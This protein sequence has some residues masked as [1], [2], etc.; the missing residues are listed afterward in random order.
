[1]KQWQACSIGLLAFALLAGCSTSPSAQRALEQA[2]VDFEA[3]SKD[4]NVRRSAGKN[5]QRAEESLAR[6][7]SFSHYWGSGEDVVHYAYLSRRY[8][9]IAREESELRQASE[10]ATRLELERSRLQLALHEAKLLDA[11]PDGEWLAGQLISL[12]SGEAGRGLVV[13][14]ADVLFDSWQA[15]LKPEATRNV[16]QVAAFLRLNEE[17]TVRVEGYNDNHGD[18]QANIELSRARAQSV[19]DMLVDLGIAPQRIQVAGYGSA[20]PVA[21]N[22]SAKGRARNRRVEIVFSDEQGVLPAER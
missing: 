8:S 19:R 18:V 17:R 5:L 11:E 2:R 12:T 7:A 10:L 13:T 21:E 22:A 16:L 6:A 20:H 9:A 14:L 15:D 3:A 1:M 4:P